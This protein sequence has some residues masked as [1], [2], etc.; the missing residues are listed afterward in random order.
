MSR[1]QDSNT[2]QVR[3]VG[4]MFFDTHQE[5]YTYAVAPEGRQDPSEARTISTDPRQVRKALRKL[6]QEYDLRI[7]YEADAGG[8]DLYRQLRDWGYSCEV[9]APSLSPKKPGDRRKNDK[10][11]ARQGARNY[12]AGEL[13][14]IAV[15]SAQREEDR[16]LIRLRGQLLKSQK[17]FKHQLRSTLRL[18]GCVYRDGKKWTK[19]HF[20][21][22]RQLEMTPGHDFLRTQ[23]LLQIDML[24]LQLGEVNHRIEA[25]AQ[26][27]RY[28]EVVAAFRAFRGIDTLTAVT[29]C[30]EVGEFRRFP[31]P[32]ELMDYFGLTC[33]ENRSGDDG[34]WL[35]I[36]KAG[37]S[38]CRTLLVEAA[39]HYER[40]PGRSQQLR[41]RQEGVPTPIIAH[42]W[43]AQQRLHTRFWY[44]AHRKARPV[45]VVAIARELTGFLW[46]VATQMVPPTSE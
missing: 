30:T 3:P 39:W 20:D 45:A 28:R 24:E 10:R 36:T 4:Y 2:R 40:K 15:P 33:G 14:P 37:N 41:K 21:W 26:T 1:P 12:R 25:L 23:L 6:E 46:A 19:R 17:R 42:A 44:L 35:H 7:C 8:Y 32:G 43:K 29:L 27:E 5:T 31:S 16:A 9:M 18:Q 13:T 34:N 11:D 22:I 38:L